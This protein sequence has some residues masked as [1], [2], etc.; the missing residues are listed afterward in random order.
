[1]ETNLITHQTFFSRL[2][3]DLGYHLVTSLKIK[4][5]AEKAERHHYKELRNDM[6]I[7]NRL[8][9]VSEKNSVAPQF[10]YAHLTMPH[11]PYY[12]DK[13]GNEYTVYTKNTNELR[14][15]YIEYLQYSNSKYLQLLNGIL[16]RAKS[17][18]IVLF[19]SDHGSR[20][21]TE[22]AET[23]YQFSTINA[24]YLPDK[25]YQQFYNGIS[26]VNVLRTLLN[27]VF[28]EKLSILPDKSFY[29]K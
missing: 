11:E 12:F 22:P 27:S 9:Q 25:N 8:L 13:N 2:S 1:M 24:I 17:N 3:R 26:N 14:A 10:T 29:L 16:K 23:K 18:T 5:F 21:F 20:L 28:N 15:R 4:Y 19:M 7:S 6:V